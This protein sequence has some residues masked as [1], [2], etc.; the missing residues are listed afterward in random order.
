MTT[1][2]EIY[3]TAQEVAQLLNVKLSWIGRWGRDNK[4]GFPSPIKLT[5]KVV[6][7]RQTEIHNWLKGIENEQRQ[8]LADYG[9]QVQE[10]KEEGKAQESPRPAGHADELR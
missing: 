3:M 4:N 6:R 9:D 5:E 2:S 8:S 1:S 10:R 7:W